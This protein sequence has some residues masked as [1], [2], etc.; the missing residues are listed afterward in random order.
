[1]RRRALPLRCLVLAALLLPSALAAGATEQRK[2]GEAK[3]AAARTASLSGVLKELSS[4]RG[5]THRRQPHAEGEAAPAQQRS[6]RF[7]FVVSARRT[8]THLVQN[9]LA[10]HL[11][12]SARAVLVKANH[13]LADPALTPPACVAWVLRKAQAT[14]GAVVLPVRDARDMVVSFYYYARTFVKSTYFPDTLEAFLAN[15]K[16]VHDVVALWAHTM[17]GWQVQPGVVEARFEDV[18]TGHIPGRLDAV[19]G[20][21]AEASR[22]AEVAVAKS[23]GRGAGGWVGSMPAD[24]ARAVKAWADA[25]LDPATPIQ[26]RLPPNSILHNIVLAGATHLTSLAPAHAVDLAA[27]RANVSACPATLLRGHTYVL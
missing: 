7:F 22:L 6:P 20:L 18:V 8:G 16:V 14:G 17:R 9:Y 24:T 5:D 2:A 23:Q 4:R 25:Y 27:V 1:M 3:L 26:L 10:A 19:L 12:P 11:P 21:S 15:D 13:I